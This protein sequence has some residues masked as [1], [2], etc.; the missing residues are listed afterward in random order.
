MRADL[1]PVA[2]VRR[3]ILGTLPRLHSELVDLS[4]AMGR[5]LAGPLVSPED[6]PSF[7]NSGMDGYA[8]RGTDV[9]EPGA[10][11]AVLSDLPAGQ[12]SDQPVGEGEAIKIMTG[13]P[14]P[15]GA[16]TVVRVED[17][18]PSEGK[19]TVG[20]AV[21][22]GTYV[23]PA[24]GDIEQGTT[25]IEA[26]TRLWA[27]Q[28]GVLA[29]LGVTN[30]SVSIRPKVAVMSTGDELAP[31]ETASLAPGMI[32]DS[33]R[34]ML[35]ALAIEAGAEVID[36]GRVPDD[37]S[38]LRMALAEGA[39]AAD[40]VVTTGGVSMGDYDVIKEVLSESAE[41]EFVTVAM[42]PGKPLGVGKVGDRPFFGLP[43]N[44]V[45]V[46]VSFEQFA[47]PAILA[48]Q[49]ARSLL[50]PRVS[51]VAGEALTSDPAKEAFLRVR[52]VDH[53]RLVVVSTGGQ[54]SNVLSGAGRADCFAVLPVG[55]AS[56]DVGDPVTLEL[57]RAVETRGAD[58]GD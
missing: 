37:A 57:F 21:A 50:R 17:A 36:L 2:E 4:E 7:A 3:R 25:V 55:V 30:P 11:L 49:G 19:V 29:A 48:M 33:N 54:A 52:V 46:L 38:R 9:A 45:S 12:V 56:V 18:T 14:L 23:R 13:A 1:R 22:V 8:V 39:A 44:P 43:G 28:V 41:V 27:A 51:G 10:V 16:D 58:D 24:G 53:D 32:R 34:P 15:D 31:P 6:V 40:V 42:S 26:G 20:P 35:I 5:V 47:R